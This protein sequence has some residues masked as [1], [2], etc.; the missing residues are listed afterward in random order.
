MGEIQSVFLSSPAAR[1]VAW[2]CRDG[3][4]MPHFSVRDGL[5]ALEHMN[6]AMHFARHGIW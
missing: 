5:L 2:G 3:R 1:A 4:R 6:N